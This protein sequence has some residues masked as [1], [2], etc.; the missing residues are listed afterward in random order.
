MNLRKNLFVCAALLITP[1]TTTAVET[2]TKDP[3]YYPQLRIEIRSW[4]P[5]DVVHSYRKHSSGKCSNG[6]TVGIGIGG[7]NGF[8]ADVRCVP[9]RDRIA[10]EISFRPSASNTAMKQSKSEVD[11]SDMRPKFIE[12]SKD[13]DGRVYLL[14]VEPEMIEVQP[15]K[16]FTVED[17]SVFDWEFPQS[18]VVLND[19]TYV[20][21]VGMGGGSL[22]GITI[23][24]VS[25]LEFSLR[26]I[27]DAKPI[28]VLQSGTLTIKTDDDQIVISGILNG[29][30]KQILQ[31]PFKV[32]VRSTEVSVSGPQYNEQMAAQ[33]ET[34]RKRKEE[35]DTS[36]TDEILSRFQ[37]FVE[38]G[39]PLLLGSSARDV[40][41]NDLAK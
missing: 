21:R 9:D 29:A 4:K 28:G 23:A 5:D 10:A 15:P 30:N 34:I 36:I 13:D 3:I 1:L 8:S 31:G 7:K 11:I 6:G 32:W 25:D 40:R 20:G 41:E 17:L 12:V 27:K 14:V 18:P 39:R 33:L 16:D 2:P 24:G 37:G 26:K 35:G 19:E 38:E 22:V